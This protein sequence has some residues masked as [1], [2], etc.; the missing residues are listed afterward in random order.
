[1]YTFSVASHHGYFFTILIIT[2]GVVSSRDVDNVAIKYRNIADDQ[3]SIQGLSA[4]DVKVS[5]SLKGVKEVIDAITAEDIVAY[6]DLKG[7]SEGE[8]D[9]EVKVEG[10][11]P[12]IE[13]KPKTTKVRIKIVKK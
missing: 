12:R 6:L 10:T 9:V 2:L 3:Y 8:H 7:Y 4:E 11:D 13:Y 5:V 1:M